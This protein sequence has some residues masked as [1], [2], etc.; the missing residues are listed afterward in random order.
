MQEE[1][2]HIKI[3][4]DTI[5]GF[6]SRPV[7]KTFPVLLCIHG[8]SSSHLSSKIQFFSDEL[9]KR[10]WGV[11]TFDL[12]YHGK[13]SGSLEHI[14]VNEN[15]KDVRIVYDY[16]VKKIKGVES[17]SLFGSS[18]G[19]MLA[20]IQAIDVPDIPLLGLSAPVSD[21]AEQ[22]GLVM[23][24]KELNQWKKKKYT[25]WTNTVNGKI[26]KIGYQFYESMLPYHRNLYNLTPKIKANTF[27]VQ[28][29]ND[30]AVPLKLTKKF[31]S[32]LTTQKEFIV[33]PKADHGFTDPIQKQNML[34]RFIEFYTLNL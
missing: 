33:V 20:I 2:I 29:D 4:S 15:V 24:E 19:G 34:N 9:P 11:F 10:G 8:F 14:R 13:S 7:A 27:I 26:Y 23:S 30:E 32:L 17:I 21:Y 28:G 16:I 18:Y 25:D 1:Q 5:A 6:F 22:K 31:Y 12:R 3:G